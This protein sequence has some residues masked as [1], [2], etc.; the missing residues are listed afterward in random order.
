MFSKRIEIFKKASNHFKK[1]S[2]SRK[3]SLKCQAFLKIALHSQKKP[4]GN[5]RIATVASPPLGGLWHKNR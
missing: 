3:I 2:N 4:R 5:F 1:A